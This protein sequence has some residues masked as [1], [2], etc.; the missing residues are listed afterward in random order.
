M[1]SV[2]E[3]NEPITKDKRRECS[4]E[5]SLLFQGDSL[6]GS[7]RLHHQVF[8]SAV[9]FSLWQGKYHEL[10]VSF[11]DV[12][13][14]WEDWGSKS[15]LTMKKSSFCSLNR[16]LIEWLKVTNGSPSC[17]KVV[18]PMPYWD[19]SSKKSMA[20]SKRDSDKVRVFAL[21]H[22]FLNLLTMNSLFKGNASVYR[23]FF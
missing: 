6:L 20:K 5:Y 16:V 12:P 4:L 10:L 8:R 11:E 9:V 1:Q 19:V 7:R 14:T 23:L 18:V 21:C 13:W 17:C 3:L 15:E 22:D 2:F